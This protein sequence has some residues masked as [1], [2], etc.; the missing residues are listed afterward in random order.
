MEVFGI[1][2]LG[3]WLFLAAVVVGGMWFDSKKR[4]TQQETLRRV[5]ESGQRIDEAMITKLMNA[6][7]DSESSEGDLKIGGIITMFAAFGLVALGWFLGR[8]NDQIFEVMLGVGALAL[9]V[10]IGL[11]VAGIMSDRW[12]REP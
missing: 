11:Y 3:F 2:A 9:I 1:G 5:V 10:G 8:L 6:T 12:N 7:E 4:E